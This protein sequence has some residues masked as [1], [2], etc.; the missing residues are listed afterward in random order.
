MM[1]CKEELKIKFDR[2]S[3]KLINCSLE[4][5]FELSESMDTKDFGETVSIAIREEL[6]REGLEDC[7]DNNLH[8]LNQ[9][10]KNVVNHFI[11]QLV[12]IF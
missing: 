4:T 6:M 10:K 7:E 12:D 3:I 9:V 11:K 2:V 5:Y 8:L 1:K